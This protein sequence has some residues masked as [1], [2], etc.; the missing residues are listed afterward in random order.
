MT[1]QALGWRVG[2]VARNKHLARKLRLARAL[3][4]NR[5][6]PAWVFIK[7]LRRI[8]FNP[9]RRHWRASKLKV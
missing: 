3:K 7:T 5:A 6:V 2:R 9:L 4:A 1:P 8:R